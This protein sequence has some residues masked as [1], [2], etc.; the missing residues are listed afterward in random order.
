MTEEKTDLGLTQWFYD[1]KIDLMYSFS[2]SFVVF[3]PKTI[4]S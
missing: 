2:S 4:I 3:P 1:Q